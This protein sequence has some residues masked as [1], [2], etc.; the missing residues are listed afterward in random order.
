M[1]DV[2]LSEA[3]CPHGEGESLLL[4]LSFADN[5]SA[6]THAFPLSVSLYFLFC[7]FSPPFLPGMTKL[8]FEMEILLY[9]IWALDL[10]TGLC[11][12]QVG[13]FHFLA[14]DWWWLLRGHTCNPAL[15]W[16]TEAEG[17][18]TI[19]QSGEHGETPGITIVVTGHVRC[20]WVS[21]C[22]QMFSVHI[23]GNKIKKPLTGSLHGDNWRI[24]ELAPNTCIY[25]SIPQNLKLE[26][27]R[28]CVGSLKISS[29]PTSSG[30]SING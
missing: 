29:C 2:T 30:E 28:E 24:L 23:S 14:L 11:D 20:F 17:G 22:P 26:W 19:G 13:P 18:Q 4:S 21:H 3:G 7:S 27:L 6:L 12:S 10:H 15:I 1:R 25:K 8:D 16:E 5:V 9:L